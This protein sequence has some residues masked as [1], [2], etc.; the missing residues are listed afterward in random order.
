MFADIAVS[1]ALAEVRKSGVRVAI[2]DFGM[3][4]SSLSYLRRLPVDI[5]K[6]DRS[7]LADVDGE[8]RSADFVGAVIAVAHAVGLSV[9]VEG[10]ETQAQLDIASAAGADLVQG[11]LVGQPLSASA[12]AELAARPAT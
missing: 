12:A 4:Y 7:F 5:V 6:L 8:A 3:G 11:F 2:D 9:V 1:L 10:I